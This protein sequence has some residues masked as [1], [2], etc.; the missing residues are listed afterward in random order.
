MRKVIKNSKIRPNYGSGARL[1]SL[2][3]SDTVSLFVFISDLTNSDQSGTI[4]RRAG[5]STP[6]WTW[7][8]KRA[9]PFANLPICWWKNST[10]GSVLP[11]AMI[12]F[13]LHWFER[14]DFFLYRQHRSSIPENQRKVFLNIQNI[15]ELY[16]LKY[17]S[18]SP[19]NF[20][21]NSFSILWSYN[22]KC[23]TKTQFR[24]RILDLEPR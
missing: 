14:M 3:D 24:N 2:L 1:R 8:T 12:L 10:L 20:P 18:E 9:I 13:L 23:I 21:R 17:D 22:Y 6:L 11:L 19:Q 7:S 16:W 15:P 5:S 4:M